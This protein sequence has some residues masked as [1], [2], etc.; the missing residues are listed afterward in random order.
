M[1]APENL[2]SGGKTIGVT[3]HVPAMQERIPAQ[4]N[5]TNETGGCSNVQIFP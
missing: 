2:Q 1:P 5:V 4:I 3:P